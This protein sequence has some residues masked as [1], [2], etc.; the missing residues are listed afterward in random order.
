MCQD[1]GGAWGQSNTDMASGQVV[2]DPSAGDVR[3]G[4][5]LGSGWSSEPHIQIPGDPSGLGDTPLPP[6]SPSGSSN[7][8][9]LN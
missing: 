2:A 7:S 3:H 5:K 6:F 8:G 4:H 1:V 9:D